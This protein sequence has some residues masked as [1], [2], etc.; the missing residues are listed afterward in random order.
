MIEPKPGE[1]L[2]YDDR[3]FRISSVHWD[4]CGCCGRI[5]A[6]CLEPLREGEEG[7][8]FVFDIDDIEPAGQL[9]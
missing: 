7:P 2:T 6:E 5:V 8:W 9:H 4:E 1:R 3:M